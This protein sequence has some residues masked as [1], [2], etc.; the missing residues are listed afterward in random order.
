MEILHMT[1][2]ELADFLFMNADN[3]YTLAESREILEAAIYMS[4]VEDMGEKLAENPDFA[5]AI[6]P[7]RLYETLFNRS[8]AKIRAL[9]PSE[10]EKRAR[11]IW[12]RRAAEAAKNRI[13]E[14]DR[15]SD[16]GKGQVT[17]SG[18]KKTTPTK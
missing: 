9:T 17:S 16:S 10:A 6:T 3:R 7:S 8:W 18:Q 2:D 1:E 11:P 14:Q 4:E 5:P 15:A 13:P 12:K